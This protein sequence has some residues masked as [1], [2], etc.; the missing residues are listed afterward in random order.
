MA[1]LTNKMT[2]LMM[3]ALTGLSL[4]MLLV[5]GIKMR[6]RREVRKLK[7]SYKLVVDKEG[8]VT[9]EAFEN[10]ELMLEKVKAIEAEAQ[11]PVEPE[12]PVVPEETAPVA[13]VEPV[14]GE[15]PP[16]V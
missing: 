5:F 7:I 14:A 15:V 6:N 4:F 2:D 10:F 8:V 16:A 13:P 3:K 9:E 1:F 11:K 12:A